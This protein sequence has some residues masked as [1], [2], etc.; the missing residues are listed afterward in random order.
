M[1]MQ[2]RIPYPDLQGKLCSAVNASG[3]W[4]GPLAMPGRTVGSR[5]ELTCKWLVS[6]KGAGSGLRVRCFSNAPVLSSADR[7]R[8]CCAAPWS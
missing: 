6:R 5:P 3:P 1:R 7:R 4:H 2:V 8:R